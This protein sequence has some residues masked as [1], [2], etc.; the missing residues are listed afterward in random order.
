VL[1]TKKGFDGMLEPYLES[2]AMMTSYV[3]PIR[4]GGR[5]VGAAGSDIA[6]RDL[7]ARIKSV[8]VLDTGYAFV[9]ADTGL[10][11]AFPKHKGWTGKQTVAQIARKQNV[12][13]LAGIPAAAMAGR[14]GH[15]ETTDP[16]T[17]KDAVLFYAPVK[18]GGWS[19]VAVAP[20]DEM[21][22][23]VH[24]LRTTLIGVG[25]LALML[26]AGALV[27]IAG[28]ISRP[29][30]EVA[31]AAERIAEGDLDVTLR[32]R[33]E[34]EVGRMAGAFGAMVSSLREKAELAE[35]IAE[36][37][38]S[39]DVEP[40]SER[41]VLGHAFRAMTLRLRAMVGELSH[42]A[43]T[44][45]Q[46]SGDRAA[47]S[48]EA[49]RAVGEIAHA[50]GD[51]ASGGERQVRMVESARNVG[52]EVAESASAG[53]S[54]AAGTV[55]AAAHARDMAEEGTRAV[56]VATDAMG[57]VRA[58]TRD[59]TE[60]IRELGARSLRI[61]GIVDTITEIAEQTNLLALNA[62][63]EAARAGEE[64]KGFAVVAEEVRKVPPLRPRLSRRG[65][66]LAQR[67]RRRHDDA[68][69]RD[70]GR[71]RRGLY[72]HDHERAGVGTRQHRPVRD[73]IDVRPAARCDRDRCVTSRARRAPRRGVSESGRQHRRP[74]RRD[75][76]RDRR[77]VD[78]V[79]EGARRTEDG[80][81]TVEQASAAFAAI[82]DA[83]GDVDRQ[84]AEIAA[85]VER[86]EQGAQ[87]MRGDLGEVA[88][89]AEASSGLDRRGVRVGAADGRVDRGDRRLGAAPGRS[90][91]AAP[92]ARRPV[93]DRVPG[94]PGAGCGRLT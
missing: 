32:A 19:F 55:E 31:G 64:G 20:K 23:G 76:G 68:R 27:L 69:R 93:R 34:D 53:A 71:D 14:S 45:T 9:A 38:L 65:H 74:D 59:A 67:H 49:G 75:P 40:Q 25:L 1:P 16:V 82:R 63:I 80:V 24:K 36:G 78:A 86:I 72:R 28:R 18:T 61:G 46:A 42:T 73:Q 2:G 29:V 26:I 12:A 4:R 39:R 15:V 62:A 92:G 66:G 17:G 50:V 79:E 7:G 70:E 91:G 57:A 84:V 56:A 88:T 6:L 5:R 89:V 77:A 90:G 11:V 83:I 8:K 60:T 3:T 21:L 81:V 47:T 44:L 85:I 58:A 41:D 94:A 87:R 35:A 48:D 37:D 22:A 30:R 54:H 10:L 51:V 13:G 52:D 33:G 43:G